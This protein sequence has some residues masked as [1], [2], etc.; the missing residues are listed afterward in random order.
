M[1][2]QMARD[3]ESDDGPQRI[4]LVFDGRVQGV[5]F[6]FTVADIASQREVKGFVRNEWDGSVRVEAE[7]RKSELE[8]F[9]RDIYRSHVGPGIRR[10]HR[11]WKATTNSFDRF[12]I[13]YR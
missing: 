7:G 9:V 4:T 1:N 10:E 5:G 8:A 12:E 6:R 11:E 2:L 3:P 13:R